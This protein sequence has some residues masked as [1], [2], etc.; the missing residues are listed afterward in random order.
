MMDKG[1]DGE[2]IYHQTCGSMHNSL[3]FTDT[4]FETS[5]GGFGFVL[6]IDP[7]AGG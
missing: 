1:R 6:R 4:A 3:R 5:L 7:A 2:V